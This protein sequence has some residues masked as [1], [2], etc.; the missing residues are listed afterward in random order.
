MPDDRYDLVIVGAGLIGLAT[1]M[2]LTRRAGDARVL[3]LEKEDGIA[4]HQSLRNSGVIHS[5]V[6]Y[7]RGSMKAEP[8]DR[9]VGTRRPKC[10]AEPEAR[11]LPE[12]GC[13]LV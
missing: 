4:R 5:G 1:A 3:V 11:G 13:R 2:A 12:A 7:R 10:G 6:Y 8:G 9:R